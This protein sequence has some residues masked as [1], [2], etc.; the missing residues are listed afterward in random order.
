MF[1]SARGQNKNSTLK[2]HCC[3][4]CYLEEENNMEHWPQQITYSFSQTDV[5]GYAGHLS[6]LTLDLHWYQC[7]YSMNSTYLSW[8]FLNTRLCWWITC[9]EC[10]YLAMPEEKRGSYRAIVLLCAGGWFSGVRG[11]E[12]SGQGR[13][14]SVLRWAHAAPHQSPEW[15]IVLADKKMIDHSKTHSPWAKLHGNHSTKQ[16]A[17]RENL[18]F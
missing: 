1:V 7:R 9:L 3:D 11:R 4:C 18:S 12:N 8:T 16:Q 5:S 6:G 13:R 2:D 15:D 17:D 10:C 14:K